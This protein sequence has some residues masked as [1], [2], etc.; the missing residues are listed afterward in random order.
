MNIIAINPKKIINI[1][2][3]RGSP[4]EKENKTTTVPIGKYVLQLFFKS[5]VFRYC[6]AEKKAAA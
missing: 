3:V 5:C 1:P 4:K 2:N 6:H